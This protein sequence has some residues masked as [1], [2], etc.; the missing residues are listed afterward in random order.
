[1]QPNNFFSLDHVIDPQPLTVTSETPVIEVIRLM[2]KWANSCYL[3][4]S[5]DSDADSLARINNSCALIVEDAQ[6]QGIFTERDLVKLIARERDLAGITVGEVMSRELI[7]LTTTGSSDI[8]T[9]LNLLQQHRIRHLPVIDES[10]R[11]LGLVSEKGI[12]H[13]LQPINLM[14]WRTVKEIMNPNVIHAPPSLLFASSLIAVIL[15]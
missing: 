9:A 2:Q 10:D 4:E 6:L 13:N 3:T 7:T 8:F 15:L 14:K 5:N 12:R 1:M 11:L